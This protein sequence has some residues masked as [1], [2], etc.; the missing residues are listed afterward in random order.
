MAVASLVM[1][2][3]PL[4]SDISFSNNAAG[5]GGDVVRVGQLV[6]IG[7]WNPLSV[8]TQEERVAAYL[9]YSCLFTYDE[10]WNGPV[11]DLARSWNQTIHADDTMTTWV[12]ITNEAYFRTAANPL[13]TSHQLTAS[14]VSYTYQLILDNAGSTW[15][16]RLTN[17]T[18]V[19]A[20]DAFTVRIDTDYPKATLLDDLAGIPIVP[21]YLW[22]VDA[23]LQ[24]DPYAAILPGQGAGTGPFLFDSWEKGVDCQFVT[25]PTYHGSRIGREV[26]IDG[27]VYTVYPDSAAL[28][29][30]MNDGT[31]DV[32]TFAEDF[33]N[34]VNVLGGGGAKV[35]VIKQPIWEAGITDIAINAIPVEFRSTGYSDGWD[36]KDKGGKLFLLDPWV[37]KAIMMTLDK[38]S[39]ADDIMFGLSTMADSV[40]QPDYW[41]KKIDNQV[42]FDPA[43][44]KQLLIDHGYVDIDS[45]GVLEV[46]EDSMSYANGWAAVGDK[47][48]DIRCQ[49]SDTD[50]TWGIIAER[51]VGWARQAGLGFTAIVENQISM[52]NQVW[53]K[54]YY[55]I[56]IWHWSWDPEPLESALGVWNTDQLHP[57]GDNC[58]MP[59]GPWWFGPL[60]STLS[61]TGEAYSSYDENFSLA[62]RTMDK[63]DRKVIVDRLQQWLYDSYCENPPVYDIG[64]HAYT[65][66]RYDGW[67]NWTDHPGRSVR[68][69]LLWLWFDLH[70]AANRSPFFNVPPAAA[71]D[72]VKDS[73]K[74][75][76]VI[77][78]DP[79]GDPLLIN[80]TFGD[81]ATSQSQL[82]GDT[83]IPQLVSATHTYTSLATSL[84]MTVS[85]WDNQTGHELTI[86]SKVNV[87]STPNLGPVIVSTYTSAS[88]TNY[89]GVPLTWSVVARDVESGSSHFGLL[90]TWSWG[91][92]TFDVFL[93]H[94]LK[95]NLAY[96]DTREH[97]WTT[98]G[99]YAVEVSVWDGFDVE[100]NTLH[101]VTWSKQCK[102]IENTAPSN[103]LISSIEGIEGIPVPCQA[104]STDADPDGLRFTWDWG[105]GSYTVN[106]CPTSAGEPMTSSVS[107]MWTAVGN[108]AVIVTADDGQGH[109][110][111]SGTVAHI[112]AVGTPVPPCSISLTVF[113]SMRKAGSEIWVNVSASDANQDALSV[114][115]DFEDGGR[116]AGATSGGT[117]GLQ[118]VNVSH[119]Y[120]DAGTYTITVHVNDSYPD[121][122]HN[123][124][125]FF[126]V[127]ILIANNP[128]IFS[129]QSTYTAFYNRTFGIA[130]VTI[131]D[132][133]G[134]ALTV[135]YDWGDGSVLTRG[136]ATCGAVHIFNRTATYVI[137]VSVNDSCGHNVTQTA[138]V[139][140]TEGNLKPTIESW[141]LAPLMP[142][143]LTG[144]TIW[145]NV[146]VKDYEGDTVTVTVDFGDGSSLAKK[147][148]TLLPAANSSIQTFTHKFS[149][150][151]AT[152]YTVCVKVMD[153][154]DHSNMTWASHTANVIVDEGRAEG[155]LSG[156]AVLGVGVTAAV[157]V[158]AA[159]WLVTKRRKGRM[160]D[161]SPTERPPK[162]E[163]PESER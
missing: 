77:A 43:G 88:S 97:S 162:S 93:K 7:I 163:P 103:P 63:A 115:L 92:G 70:P 39:I 154:M 151:N 22:S 120:S 161:G 51:W 108:Y 81:G 72:V 146:T 100:S 16:S 99:T 69:G 78:S 37:R 85:L 50:P 83:S 34:Y 55:D 62:L 105:N 41:H 28:A 17:V 118:Y 11:E 140:V 144:R 84:N 89:I 13:D 107:H 134:D 121:G 95:D 29:L 136:N 139:T 66:Y 135:W 40:I 98:P 31:E 15:E 71:Y 132:E 14:D 6:E 82:G 153:G 128:P 44:A 112:G 47:L 94:P 91:D 130:P 104:V 19:V 150:A 4:I 106:D 156:A 45:D 60:N 116:A 155:G 124:T 64:L 46:T 122:S 86:P 113:P 111:S 10:D 159:T 36:Q 110:S 117:M 53:Y 123:I 152:G 52:T 142:R 49:A 76:S 74:T 58:Q 68:S 143:Y 5:I 3:L 48:S 75:F 8:Q 148:V 96:N 25:A 101:N 30:A 87:I 23:A 65:D 56:W 79:D 80:W 157:A 42:T 102:I 126:N 73:P 145:F 20:V 18:D 119:V 27:V 131:S 12:N 57:G 1:T 33:D 158:V 32:A 26:K 160:Q 147:Q 141:T 127:D 54:A 21:Q 59:M 109:N 35:H 149:V 9:V 114:Y 125:S 133:D 38:N 67:G 61:P 90:I 2:A 129:L 137:T 24:D 138:E